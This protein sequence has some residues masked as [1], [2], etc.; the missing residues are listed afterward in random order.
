MGLL[1]ILPVLAV[2][3]ATRSFGYDVASLIERLPNGYVGS[4]QWDGSAGTQQVAIT[5]T[6]L[7]PLDGGKVEARGCGRYDAS[8]LV[9]DIRVKM[10]ID[11]TT[12]DVEMWELD[13]IGPAGFTTD[14]SH[15]GRLSNDLQRLDA[16][17]QTTSSGQTG[18]LHLA[19]GLSITCAAPSSRRPGS[20]EAATKQS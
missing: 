5:F 11:A 18:R 12:L 9:T 15:K 6:A 7:Q 10:R 17:W 3:F 14:G 1:A 19:A 16:E 13:P 20:K 4:F 8:G 2:G